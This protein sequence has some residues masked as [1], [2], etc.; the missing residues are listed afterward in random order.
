MKLQSQRTSMQRSNIP[1]AKE[2]R[3]SEKGLFREGAGGET[4][5][6][7]HLQSPLKNNLRENIKAMRDC[8]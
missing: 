5:L 6:F 4:Y 3:E 7:W 1:S 8:N 2:A